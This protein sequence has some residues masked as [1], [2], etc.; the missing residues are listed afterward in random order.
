MEFIKQLL[1]KAPEALTFEDVERFFQTPR[2]ESYIIEFKSFREQAGSEQM[3]N[4]IFKTICAFLNSEGGL[5]IWGAPEG[6][7]EEGHKEKQFVGELKPLSKGIEKDSLIN[8]ISSSITPTPSGIRAFDLKKGD[9]IV[10][11][12]EIDRSDYRPHQTSNIYY[13]RLDGQTR[14][15]PHDFLEA[16]FRKIRYP[17]L[18]GYINCV[19]LRSEYHQIFL[20]IKI[21]I[22][23]HTKS[24][25]EEDV[26]VNLITTKGRLSIPV[27]YSDAT[28]GY[29]GKMLKLPTFSKLL[30]Y[31]YSEFVEV[32]VT[33]SVS[34]LNREDL[35]NKLIL[36]FGGRYSP[37]KMSEYHLNIKT[38]P[39]NLNEIVTQYRENLS[40]DEWSGTKVTQQEQVD[41]LLGRGKYKA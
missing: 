7:K 8:K 12:F 23:N 6:K 17:N 24:Q 25:N 1:G 11:L 4:N 2:A 16:L 37:I 22:L 3:Y 40:I 18:G 35:D 32:R 19:S 9:K 21:M 41:M 20:G 31:G 29:D 28:L 36:Q 10:Y 38:P 13:M 33:Y 30:H 14:P 5:L 34:E 27:G 39:P 15:A 26:L